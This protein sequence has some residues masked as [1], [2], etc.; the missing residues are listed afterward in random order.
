MMP[1]RGWRI[2]FVFLL[3]ACGTPTS[4][5]RG[6]AAVVDTDAADVDVDVATVDADAAIEDVDATIENVDAATDATDGPQ[7]GQAQC[8]PL[9]G[10]SIACNAQEHCEYANEDPTG[11]RKWDVWIWIPPGEFQMGSEGEGGAPEEQPVHAVTITTGFYIGKFE[12]VVEQYEACVSAGGCWPADTSTWDAFGWGTNTSMN[13]RGDHPQNG[14]TLERAAIFCAWA[15]P[16]GRLPSEAEHEYART[17][18]VHR[19]YP[20][21]DIPVP[22]CGNDTAVFNEVGGPPGF[23][24]GQGGT[25]P[26]GSKTAGLAWSGGV[27]MSGNLWEWCEDDYH[28]SYVG[29]PT[30]G[31]AWMEPSSEKRVIRGGSFDYPAVHLRSAARHG[32]WP[33][34]HH[35]AFGGRCA[36]P[37]D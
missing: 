22:T 11:W 13:D 32:T 37:A 25:W 30:D 31:S 10:Y 36:R 5:I 2:A 3:A 4:E 23:G 29:A 16:G 18:P 17:G 35:A 34:A 9:D 27:D 12:I 19:V 6:G 7:C 15:A 24:C 20:W 1:I 26:V 14:L 8:P 33:G 21:G 28:P